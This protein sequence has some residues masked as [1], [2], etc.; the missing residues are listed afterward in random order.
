M[1]IKPCLGEYMTR[2]FRPAVTLTRRPIP[3]LMITNGGGVTEAQR[4]IGLGKNFD[5]EV[6]L[7]D[8]KT[9]TSDWT[10]SA[11]TITHTSYRQCERVCG[12]T[13]A[14]RWRC[15]ERWTENCR[16]VRAPPL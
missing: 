2:R 12:Q 7:L 14:G 6:S 11:R 16:I 5:I 4:R 10:K 9:L 13:R 8:G 15:W 3:Y 1:S